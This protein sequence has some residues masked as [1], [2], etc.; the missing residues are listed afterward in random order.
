MERRPLGDQ[1]AENQRRIS[2]ADHKNRQ[3]QRLAVFLSKRI[4]PPTDH[5]AQIA[6]DLLAAISRAKRAHQRDPDLHRRQ[7][8][9]RIARQFERQLGIATAFFGAL[10]Q[11]APAGGNDR[12]LGRGEESV[13]QDQHEDQEDFPE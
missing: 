6:D 12:N 8:A 11:P 4:W 13:G 2:K 3:P 9:I 1:L 7:E 5:L 10:F